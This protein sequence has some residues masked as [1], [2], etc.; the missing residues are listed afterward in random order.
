[1]T[2]IPAS[3]TRCGATDRWIRQEAS[4]FRQG[5]DGFRNRVQEHC[6]TPAGSMLGQSNCWADVS[7]MLRDLVS[8]TGGLVSSFDAAPSVK[9]QRHGPSSL[10][11]I[12]TWTLQQ[13]V[14]SI[15]HL[16]N[17]Q[18]HECDT[19]GRPMCAVAPQFRADGRHSGRDC[20]VFPALHPGSRHP[21]VNLAGLRHGG[22]HPQELR[23]W[24]TGLSGCQAPGSLVWN[25]TSERQGLTCDPAGAAFH[26]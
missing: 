25:P 10:G 3:S 4:S 2:L 15:V 8:A 26:T 14:V 13:Y 1:M 24:L 12:A 17:R 9:P 20:R 11:S 19:P 16:G 5:P 6:R 7:P 22:A 21:I 23:L 18:P